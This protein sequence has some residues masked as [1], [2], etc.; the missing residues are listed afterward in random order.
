MCCSSLRIDQLSLQLTQ[1]NERLC[2]RLPYVL[3]QEL[4]HWIHGYTNE[5]LVYSCSL[6]QYCTS[7]L[8]HEPSSALYSST[9]LYR[10]QLL[11][12]TT[13]T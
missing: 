9:E 4:W 8:R 6:R 11:Q 10:R 12:N 13:S 2:I 5:P 7:A 3:V 1:D